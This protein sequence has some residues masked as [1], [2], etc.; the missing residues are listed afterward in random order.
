MQVYFVENI[1]YSFVP[2]TNRIVCLNSFMAKKVELDRPPEA[3]TIFY[4]ICG[5]ASVLT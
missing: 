3:P 2:I 1:Y 5:M 4:L